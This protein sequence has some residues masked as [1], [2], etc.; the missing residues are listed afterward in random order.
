[1]ERRCRQFPVQLKGQ[2]PAV[3]RARNCFSSASTVQQALNLWYSTGEDT[4][5]SRFFNRCWSWSALLFP[6]S[7]LSSSHS[8][9]K[10]QGWG[11]LGFK[12]PVP[13]CCLLL[14][15][16]LPKSQPQHNEHILYT[17]ILS[18]DTNFPD[19]HY[20]VPV[21]ITFMSILNLETLIHSILPD[22]MPPHTSWERSK[23]SVVYLVSRTAVSNVV[24]FDISELVTPSD[25]GGKVKNPRV[26]Y[27]APKKFIVG[28]GL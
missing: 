15:P 16:P 25:S 6:S 23:D 17:Q 1:M 19:Y 2:L 27:Q 4:Y 28:G 9:K 14:L 5:W 12:L 18:F 21:K 20:W 13:S 8:E 10:T 26:A 11:V 3:Q 7:P 22:T 24:K